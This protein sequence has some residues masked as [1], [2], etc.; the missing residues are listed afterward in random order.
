MSKD[1][2]ED[3][4]DLD[5]TFIDN[6][7]L[8]EI[9][10]EESNKSKIINKN[11]NPYIVNILL[12]AV[13]L[14]SLLYFGSN[15]ISNNTSIYSLLCCLV[16]TIFSFMYT[17]VCLTYKGKNIFNVI[18]S[19]LLLIIF[20]ILGV[21][22]PFDSNYISNKAVPIF[23]GKSIDYVV[24]WADKNNIN[25][26]Q[27]YEYSDV[28]EEYSIIGQDIKYNTPIKDIDSITIT[29]SEGPNPYKEIIVPNMSTWDAERVLEFIKN[30]YLSNVNVEFISSDKLQDTL[31]DQS[32]IGTLKRNDELKLTFSYGEELGYDEVK[33][34]DFTNK[35]KFEVEFYMKQHQLRYEFDDEFDEKIKKGYV[36]KQS[37]NAGDI[38]KINDDKIKVTISKGKEIKVPNL[39]DYDVSKITKWAVDNKVKILFIYKYDDSVKE[40]KVIGANY[41]DGEVI[42]QGTTIKVTLSKGTLKMPKFKSYDDFKDWA[43]KYEIKYN[44]EREFNNNVNI[45]EVISYSVKAGDVIKNNETITIKISDGKKRGVPDVVGMTKAKATSTLKDAGLN[46]AYVYSYD[47]GE[48]GI[49]LSQSI[50]AGS[51]VSEDTTITLNISTDDPDEED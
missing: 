38:V 24:E 4:F 8:K 22:R 10:D 9:I 46:V 7:V 1:K 5:N 44:E 14:S 23:S 26:I 27:D 19:C 42:E 11:N 15:I 41:D 16:I 25:L 20:F 13:L 12:I 34:I 6:N 18:I 32:V 31:I 36:I 48:K 35:S 50:S 21:F 17:M 28:V 3:T 43:D 51:D 49:V 40:G 30:N 37:K 2:N 39:K 45:G 33:L 47:S 29:I